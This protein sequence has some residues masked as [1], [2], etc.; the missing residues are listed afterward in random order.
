MWGHLAEMIFQIYVDFDFNVKNN[1]YEMFTTCWPKVVPKL[2]MLRIYWNLAHLID[3]DWHIFLI[4]NEF[5]EYIRINR[6]G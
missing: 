6:V 4:A 5:K 3:S 1:F 2:K